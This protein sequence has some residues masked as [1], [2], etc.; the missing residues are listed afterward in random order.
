M[1][2]KQWNSKE[3]SVRGEYLNTGLWYGAP[4]A[5]V[6]RLSQPIS[7]RENLLRFYRGEEYA[8]LPDICSDEVDITP[9]CNP[10]FI[11][12]GYEGGLDAFGV[13]WIPVKNN[14]NLP[15]F[16]EPGFMLIEDIAD[17]RTLTWPDVES[18]DW[19]GESS[20]FNEQ[21]S[22]DDRLRRGI[23]SSGYFE[24]LISIMTFEN[25]AMALVEDPEETLS[26]FEALTDLNIKI[27]DHMIDD[28]HCES[29]MIHDDWAAQRSPFFSLATCMELIV[30]PMKRLV[31]HAHDRGVIF[32]LHSCGNGV[33]LVPAMK[34]AGIDAWQGNETA[35]EWDAAFDACQKAGILLEIYPVLPDTDDQ[36]V[37]RTY[38]QDALEKYSMGRKGLFDFYEFNPDRLFAARKDIYEIGRQLA[39]REMR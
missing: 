18:W 25:A 12:S 2:I 21:H 24:R 32:T 1:S 20:R 14:T 22:D 38:I 5:P 28:F 37:R 35:F 26:F 29:I 16:V 8:W 13:K 3:L 33:A 7:P 19:K 11:A 30:P 31:Q 36:T 23:I 10:D 39:I 34:A 4:Y 17:W 27:M 9:D 15:A 6:Q